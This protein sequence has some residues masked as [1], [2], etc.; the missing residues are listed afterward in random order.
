MLS[1]QSTHS[2]TAS[3]VPPALAVPSRGA[4]HLAV[5]SLGFGPRAVSPGKVG[6]PRRRDAPGPRTGV[7]SAARQSPS[8]SKPGPEWVGPDA[9]ASTPPESAGRV[10][11]LS[12]DATARHGSPPASVVSRAIRS[13]RGGPADDRAGDEAAAT[14]IVERAR[15]RRDYDHANGGTRAFGGGVPGA[16]RRGDRRRSRRVGEGWGDGGDGAAARG[17]RA[18]LL[19]E[20]GREPR[21]YGRADRVRTAFEGRV[22]VEGRRDGRRG[23]RR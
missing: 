23:P 17:R 2:V 16:G 10:A 1:P 15:G 6:L 5:T 20:R 7:R 19:R 9:P 11:R 4:V 22:G 18:G 13:R 8:L 12:S 21:G 3:R 14:P